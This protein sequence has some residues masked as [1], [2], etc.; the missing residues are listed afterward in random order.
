MHLGKNVGCVEVFLNDPCAPSQEEDERFRKVF[1]MDAG[2][3]LHSAG[4]VS[5]GEG[6][7]W[8]TVAAT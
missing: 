6:Y 4:D 1:I 3:Q 2:T 7:T 8:H 5:R